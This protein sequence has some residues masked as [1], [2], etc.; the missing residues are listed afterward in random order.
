LA[1]GRSLSEKARLRELARRT[2]EAYRKLNSAAA[3][4]SFARNP[5]PNGDPLA[6][7]SEVLEGVLADIRGTSSRNGS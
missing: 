2:L 4:A 6:D 5:A 7:V 3:Q 1:E